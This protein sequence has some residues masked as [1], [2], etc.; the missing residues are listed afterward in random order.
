MLQEPHETDIDE[1]VI[2]IQNVKNLEDMIIGFI[3]SEFFKT[4]KKI[5]SLR[6]AIIFL[7]MNTMQVIIIAQIVSYLFPKNNPILSSYHKMCYLRHTIGTAVA[8]TAIDEWLPEENKVDKYELFAYGVLHDIGMALY[9]I[10]IPE[11]V[12]NVQE[13]II[14]GN[15]PIVAE[16]IAFGGIDHTDIGS[17]FCR[18]FN[19]PPNIIEIIENHHWPKKSTNQ[20]RIIHIL[21]VADYISY[22]YYRDFL[23]KKKVEKP[24]KIYL[25]P[26]PLNIPH[27]VIENIR[28][29]LPV[30][31]EET[32]RIFKRF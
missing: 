21:S 23:I 7:G 17:W 20:S 28:W 6:E 9:E 4:P 22:L 13:I 19:F 24:I 2:R 11:V 15:H 18:K 31:V 8:A 5:T 3:N 12:D 16:R 1:L 26:N 30:L 27:E 25:P 10:C 14:R 29:R 32:L